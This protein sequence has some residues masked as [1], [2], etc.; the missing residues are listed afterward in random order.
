MKMAKKYTWIN[1]EKFTWGSMIQ[2]IM[3]TWRRLLQSILGDENDI[4]YFNEAGGGE[5]Y[6]RFLN[7]VQGDDHIR[8]SKCINQFANVCPSASDPPRD[9]NATTK[10]RGIRR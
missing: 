2:G 5:K 10:A 1:A 3:Y 8:L 4:G 9:S 6:I 7:E